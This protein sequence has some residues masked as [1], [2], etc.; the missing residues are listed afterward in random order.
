MKECTGPLDLDLVV[1]E[2]LAFLDLA[3]DRFVCTGL[4]VFANHPTAHSAQP[5]VQ[6]PEH[7]INWR[8]EGSTDSQL[9]RKMKNMSNDGRLNLLISEV[10]V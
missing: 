5:Y 6:S 9:R 7:E 4:A 2:S 8:S 10:P 1:Y 3:L